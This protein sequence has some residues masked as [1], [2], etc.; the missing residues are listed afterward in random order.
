MG[1]WELTVLR[2][3]GNS[4]RQE[5]RLVAQKVARLLIILMPGHI[6]TV[7]NTTGDS[8]LMGEDAEE[9][10][11]K[12]PKEMK[13]ILGIILSVMLIVCVVGN[14]LILVALPYVRHKDKDKKQFSALHSSTF[15]LLLHLSFADILY[16]VLGFPHFIHGLVVDGENPFEFPNGDN[17]CWFLA[18]L[19]NW[20]AEVDF[21]TMGAIAFL[22]CKQMFCKKCQEMTEPN[23]QEHE[24]SKK[25]VAGIIILVW[26]WSLLFILPDCLQ[27]TGGYKWSNTSYGCDNVYFEGEAERSYG[28]I[29][30]SYFIILVI[31]TSCSIVAWR[32]RHGR[33]QNN[34]TTQQQHIKMLLTLAFTYTLCTLPASL[35]SWR[36]FDT[37]SLIPELSK[38]IPQTIFSCLYWSMYCINF[39]LYLVPNNEIRKGF[40][41]FFE[42]VKERCSK[43]FTRGID[44]IKR[45]RCIN[46][47]T[48]DVHEDVSLDVI[49]KENSDVEDNS[50]L[51]ASDISGVSS[52]LGTSN[53]TTDDESSPESSD[54]D[55][56]RKIKPEKNCP[57]VLPCPE[58]DSFRDTIMI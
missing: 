45:N 7:M 17:L 15:L 16:G 3:E 36:V 11:D 21:T 42:D 18:M 5:H 19:R 34:L 32:F 47:E 37:A 35:F 46:T 43:S 41:K 6:T 50:S 27:L 29:I 56:I 44:K 54:S 23:H 25:G 39:L 51:D 58:S 9:D 12:M 49:V 10:T 24:I 57:N 13:I 22:A 33:I 20:V 4:R 28:L 40:D 38:Q 55:Y 48:P 2:S 30:N 1:T 26:I 31:I 53:M 14:S 8:S 52:S